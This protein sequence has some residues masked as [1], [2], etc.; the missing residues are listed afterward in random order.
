MSVQGQVVNGLTGIDQERLV[1]LEFIR[2][3]EAAA[4]NAYKWMGKGDKESGDFA[5]CDAIRGLFDTVAISGMVTIGEGIKD[6][7]P[8]IFKGEKLGTWAAGT[9][10][11]AIALDPIDGT[12]IVSKGLPGAISV[13]AAATAEH[14]DEDPNKL[15]AD[16]PSFYMNKISFGPRV[17]QGPGR[18]R[19]DNTVQDN[20]EILALKLGKRV[21][22]L[23]IVV[24]D[25]PRHER[26]IHDIRRAGAAIRLISDGDIAA[27]IAPSL[28]GSGVDL[29]MGIGGSP[30]AVLAATGIRCL[31]GEIL[32]QMWPRDD[33]ERKAL[34]ATGLTDA[35]LNRVYMSEDLARGKRVLFAASGISDSTLLP[36]IR[37][38][39]THVITHSILMR[40]KNQTVRYIKTVHN[41]DMKT[42]RLRS[43][44]QDHAL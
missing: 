4:L 43:D 25:R 21:Q 9:I 6:Q 35:E 8:G 16:I 3:T 38:E 15:L 14:P 18:I 24:L 11:M 41:L 31:G 27:A 13:I 28:P 17:K 2:A 37:Y 34:K 5:A 30:E 32:C 26:L 19:L 20:L 23:T 42:T 10:K 7:A 39:D 40:A 1:G 44:Q 12:T 36:G 33:E 22:D 29:Y